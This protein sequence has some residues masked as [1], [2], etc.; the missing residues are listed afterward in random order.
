MYT[1]YQRH[2]KIKFKDIWCFLGFFFMFLFTLSQPTYI[3]TKKQRKKKQ[4]KIFQKMTTKQKKDPNKQTNKQ[5]NKQSINKQTKKKKKEKRKNRTP[6]NIKKITQ[7]KTRHNCLEKL[8]PQITKLRWIF[9]KMNRHYLSPKT[10]EWDRNQAIFFILIFFFF[11][12]FT[13]FLSK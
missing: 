10:K 13:F 7:Y 6:P 9:V 8:L 2:L 5:T 12:F 1:E 4:Q 11:Y 3:S